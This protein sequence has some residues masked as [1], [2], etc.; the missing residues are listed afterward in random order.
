MTPEPPLVIFHYHYRGDTRAAVGKL[1]YEGDQP[2]AETIPQPPEAFSSLPPRIKLY[3]N[4]LVP[5]DGGGPGRPAQFQCMDL[6]IIPDDM[7]A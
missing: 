1:V 3:A 2:F 4:K 5:I 7:P 6:V